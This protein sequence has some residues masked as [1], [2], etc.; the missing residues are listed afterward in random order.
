[1]GFLSEY[2]TPIEPYPGSNFYVSLNSSSN[3]DTAEDGGLGWPIVVTG[4][5]RPTTFRSSGYTSSP[6]LQQTGNTS[7][8]TST[9]TSTSATAAEPH[10]DTGEWQSLYLPPGVYLS[11]PS[12][13]NVVFRGSVP[14]R[15]G[16]GRGVRGLDLDLDLDLD[17][18]RGVFGSGQSI[19][20]EFAFDGDVVVSWERFWLMLDVFGEIDACN[21]SCGPGGAC[22]PSPISPSLK[23]TT[24]S[25]SSRPSSTPLAQQTPFLTSFTC[26]C[27]PGFTG[28]RCMDCLPGF[29]GPGCT[30]CSAQCGGGRCDDGPAGTGG[31]LGVQGNST[32]GASV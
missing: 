5:S 13:T 11:F 3:F 27:L 16:L 8:T 4:P 23:T 12:Y 24:P 2:T 9:T 26:V 19:S 28:D 1:M 6:I 14:L 29:Y 17:V 32:Q 18:G 15:V 10:T 25:N 7:T 30:A 21:P 20:S 22:L 31:C